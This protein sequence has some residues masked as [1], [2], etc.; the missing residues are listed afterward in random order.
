MI[1]LAALIPVAALVAFPLGVLPAAPVTWLAMVVLVIGSAGVVLLSVPLVTAAASVALI[2]YA[3]ALVVAQP[4][5]DPITA[6][7]FGATLVVLLALVHFA[8][9]V[10]GAVI[11]PGVLAAQV[12]HWL[13]VV[14]LGV[15]VAGV[16]TAG[17]A[18]LG[19]VLRGASLPMVVAAAALGALLAV[20]SVIALV[21]TPP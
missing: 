19:L 17:G 15:V 9:R 4:P 16:L 1:R 3:L 12:R 8:G 7:A 10:D 6:I 5:V 13:A 11:G 14:A 20:A 18:A 21:T 2:A